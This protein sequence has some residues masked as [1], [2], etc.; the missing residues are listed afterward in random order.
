M[1]TLKVA[2]CLA[3]LLVF[4]AVSQVSAQDEPAYDT[5]GLLIYNVWVRPTAPELAEGAT[6]EP[7]LPGTT[8]S[9]YMT[10]HNTF[11][12]DYQLVAVNTDA[13]EMSHIH[14]TTMEG[15]LARMLMIDAV[16][17]PAGETVT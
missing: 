3:M 5:H 15:D 7:P 16:D 14:E 1:S 17:I 6:P 10:I 12:N 11:E 9:V 8:T 2:W 13:A 4:G